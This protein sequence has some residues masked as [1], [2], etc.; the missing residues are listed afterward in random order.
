MRAKFLFFILII[1]LITVI[2]E[3][4]KAQS[5]QQEK[6][7]SVLA[8][9]SK[10]LKA[11]DADAIYALTGNQFKKSLD[12]EAFRK[13]A[14]Q[15]LFPLGEIKEVLLVS[16]INNKTA[17][18]KVQFE[19]LIMQLVMSLDENDKIE[20]FLFRPF[21]LEPINKPDP[22]ASSNPLSTGQDKKVDTVARTYIQKINT[23]GLSIGVLKNGKISVYNYGEISKGSGQ[24]P[25]AET[26]FEIGSITKTF[27]ATLLAY[28][29]N[30]G[31][32]KLTDQVTKFLPDSVAANPE[33]KAITL[34]NLSN[35]T[36]GLPPLPDNF[37]L[38]NPYDRLNPYKNYDKQLLFS[39]LKRCHLNTKPGEKYAY[40]NL[41]VGL[42]GVILE[43]I[44]GKPF[45][46]MVGEVI[47]NPL[48]MKSTV[49]HIYPM[50]TPRFAPV[51]NDDGRQTAPWDFDALVSCGSLRSSV[52]DLL[53]YTKANLDDN[54]P[55][56]LAKAFK[57]THEITFANDAKL[58]LAWHI[59]LVDGVNYYFH[60]GDTNGSSSFLAFNKEKNLAV[61]VLSNASANTDAL[62]ANILRKLQ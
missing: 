25:T 43:K 8:L 15:Q 51:Y 5:H 46:Q 16:F 28:Y 20:L 45:E 35:H 56:P 34:V 18:Y 30:E 12:L 26:L 60:N 14:D 4:S 38:Q 40:S 31:K 58:G 24:L 41:A 21:K 44:S 59:I 13:I 54:G 36:S 55:T 9:V 52:N 39:Y 61:I 37:A 2:S 23:V 19:V 22:V 10:H 33:L 47:C 1:A 53:L 11:K 7:D 50:L 48:G 42:L 27:T 29:V 6:T 49:Q 57:L 17:S 62:G 3:N 32:I